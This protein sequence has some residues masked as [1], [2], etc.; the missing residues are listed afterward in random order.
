MS[1][2]ALVLGSLAV[3]AVC[4]RLRVSSPLVLVLAGLA[5]SFV[6]AVPDFRINPDLGLLVVLVPLLYSA[7]LD[8]SYLG[9]R[10]NIRPIGLL[11]VGLVIFSTAASG[12]AAY[13]LGA[14]AEVAGAAGAGGG[15]GAAGRGGRHRGGAAAGVAPADDD[16]P[17]RREP[18]ERR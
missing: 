11:A 6:P 16:H 2:I 8:S 10:A 12:A 3:T 18:G 15:G 14:R 5:V 13:R 17:G 7:A 1:L 9:F 4:R